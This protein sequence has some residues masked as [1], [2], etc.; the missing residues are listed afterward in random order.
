MMLFGIVLIMVTFIYVFVRAFLG[1]KNVK[2]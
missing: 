1:R 2:S